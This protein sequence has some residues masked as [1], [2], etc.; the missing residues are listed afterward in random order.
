MS[1]FNSATAACPACA[2]PRQFQLVASVNADRRPDLRKAILD[3]RFQQ[4]TCDGC[5]NVFKAPPLLTYLDI[6]RRQW[7]LVQPY[8]EQENWVFAGEIASNGFAK[9]YGDQA[10]A[11]ARAMG[12]G[13][14]VRVVFGWAAL[15]EKLRCDDL[16]LDDVTLELLK[17]A[18]LRNVPDA[19]ISDAAELR[20]VAAEGDELLF[21]WVRGADERVLASLRVDRSQ[22]DQVAAGGKAWK[23]LRDD[24]QSHPFVDM[25]RMLLGPVAAAG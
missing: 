23:A 18:I 25:N 8:E 19:P 9:A 5:G 24:M 21:A 10:P 12:K 11:A 6:G 7:I 3:G 1:I 17:I 2:K 16:K 4:E 15:R 20:L 22:Y 14:R 13:L